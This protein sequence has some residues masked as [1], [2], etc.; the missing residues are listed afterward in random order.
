MTASFAESDFEVSTPE[1]FKALGHPLRHRLM[2][3]LGEPATI[4]QLSTRMGIPKGSIAHHLNV[5]REAGMVRVVATRRV[6]GGTEQYYQRSAA[7][8]SMAPKAP[9]PTAAALG[10]IAAEVIAAEDEPLLLLRHVRLTPGQ[11]EQLRATLETAVEKL[12]PASDDDDRYG[13]VVG[14]YRQRS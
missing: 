2:F 7:K 11:A 3:A 5:L 4:S 1:H 10:A 14:L 13:M 12:Q 6:R 8:I 9:E